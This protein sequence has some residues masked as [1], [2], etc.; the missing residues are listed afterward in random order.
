MIMKLGMAGNV[1]DM[2]FFCNE[3]AKDKCPHAEEAFAELV[4][5]FVKN[6][7]FKEAL[8]VLEI[9]NLGK[10]KPP[11]IHICNVMLRTLVEDQR[12]LETVLFAYKEIVKAGIVPNVDTLNY[13]IEVL[14]END[15]M[16][17]ALDQYRRMNR[18]GCVP[19]S[20]TFEILICG[21]CKRTRV[22]ESI[23]VL[24]EMFKLECG[25]DLNFCNSVLPLLCKANK[26]DEVLR[27]YKMMRDSGVLVDSLVY[28]VLIHCLCENLLL[29]DAIVL[30]EDMLKSGVA[31]LVSIY[32]DIVNG[33][34]KLSKFSNASNLLEENLVTE[35]IPHNA[36]L[37]GYCNAGKFYEAYD[38]LEKM[39]ERQVADSVSWSV[40]I[41][42]SYI[43]L[44]KE[45]KFEDALELFREACVR[46]WVLD[47]GDYAELI[48]CLCLIKRIQ[49]AAEVF[50]FLCSKGCTISSSSFDM[51]VK[52]TCLSGKLDE[53]IS[54]YS[55]AHHSGISC[56]LDTHNAILLGLSESRRT[57]DIL[58]LFSRM[59]VGGCAF[60]AE[61]YSVLINSLCLE[62]MTSECA[63][64]LDQMVD[65]GIIPCSETV[66]R[67]VSFMASH[68]QLHVVVY[69]LN[70]LISKTGLFSLAINKMLIHGLVKE[71]HKRDACKLLD[72]MLDN[73][74]VPDAVTHS[75]LIGTVEGEETYGVTEREEYSEVIIQILFC[76]SSFSVLCLILRRVLYLHD[77]QVSHFPFLVIGQ[78][79]DTLLPL[80][81]FQL[82]LQGELCGWTCFFIGV[83]A[84]AFGSLYY[85]LNAQSLS[86]CVR[87]LTEF[88][89]DVQGA[90]NGKRHAAGVAGP[91]TIQHDL[92]H[93]EALLLAGNAGLT[94]LEDLGN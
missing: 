68:S 34:C 82:C 24:S 52:G 35:V 7:R 61:T 90:R 53:A 28:E 38:Y 81:P 26:S 1:Q 11:S 87:P 60:N 15:K 12:D 69:T 51:L 93:C 8:R 9:M 33:L 75:L 21:L 73:G 27:L 45:C 18:K 42:G 23:M 49:E 5:S 66:Y 54:L 3:M 80:K 32:V 55:L 72:H 44:R 22:D 47:S 71:G 14:C 70:K 74:W 10:F 57:K 65:D 48:E 13:L 40:L 4:D 77:F 16:E 59:V 17:S 58:L 79:V 89:C 84:V 67:V 20:R 39:V 31:P 64:L 83:A 78:W 85:H 25:P 86:T 50:H 76:D 6:R 92:D 94:T 63:W 30:F 46:D 88:G 19:N 37:E 41:R 43:W 62:K 91:R 36:L 2:E 56:N 29:D